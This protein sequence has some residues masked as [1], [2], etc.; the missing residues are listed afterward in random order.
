M[1]SEPAILCEPPMTIT[2]ASSDYTTTTQTPY[3][4]LVAKYTTQ[5]PRYTSYP[6]ALQFKQEFTDTNYRQHLDKAGNY[7]APLSIY[8]HIPFCRWLCYYCGCNKIV[9]KNPNATRQYLDHLAIEIELLSKHICAPRKVSQLHF[10][11]GTPTYLDDAEL[12]ELIHLLAS[13][14]NF[15]DSQQREY[16]IEIDP[17]T[18]D[19]RRLA[20][21][22]GLGFNRLS[23]GIQ[24]TDPQVQKA[25]NRVQRTEQIFQL[26][27]AARA[28]RFN[29]ISFN[30]IYGLPLQSCETLDRSLDDIIAL[31]PDRISLYNYAHLPE[32][33]PPQRAI[34]RHTL[35]ISDEKLA[36]ILLANKRLSEAGYIYIGMDHFVRPTDEL[37]RCQKEGRLQRNFQGYSTRLAPDVLGIGVSAISSIGNCYAQNNKDLASYYQKLDAGQLPIDK[38]LVKT[39]EDELRA[40]VIMELACNL[41]VSA[42]AFLMKFKHSFWEKFADLLPTLREMQ[43]D[44]LITISADG[45]VVSDVGRLMLRNVCMVFDQYLHNGTHSYSKTV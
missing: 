7:A 12:T 24:D 45:I 22:R 37:A 15:E 27:D 8:V 38:G 39:P 6:S 17:R 30:L 11:G 16:S 35:P 40:Y 26:V 28:L 25:I 43:Q 41:G 32:H 14:F 29:S 19:D 34:E 5:G 13:H 44:G 2:V 18:V 21:L 42:H 20:L 1:P 3:S 9:T 31:Q 36:M 33:F 23:F 10:G 4:E